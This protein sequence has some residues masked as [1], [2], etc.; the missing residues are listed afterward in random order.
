MN[1]IDTHFSIDDYLIPL[2]PHLPSG[3]FAA[4][5]LSNIRSIARQI[6]GLAS[7]FFGFESPLGIVDARADFL[8]CFKPTESGREI[9]SGHHDSLH[10]PNQY[11][12]TPAWQRVKAFSETWADPNSSLYNKVENTW[13]EFDIAENQPAIPLPSFFFGTYSAIQAKMPP[14]QHQ[15]VTGGALKILL[16]NTL[17]IDTQ[18]QLLTCFNALPDGAYVFQVGTMLARETDAVRICIR[19]IAPEQVVPYLLEVGWSGSAEELKELV[20]R[21]SGLVDRVDLDLDVGATVY[22]KIGLECYLNMQPKFEP[23]WARFLNGLV[24]KGLCVPEKQKALLAYPGYN[25]ERM[26]T[27]VWPKQLLTMSTLLGAHYLSMI[28]RSIHHIKIVYQPEAPLQAKAYLAV[29]HSFLDTASLKTL[30]MRTLPKPTQPP[31]Q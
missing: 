3:L 31:S 8:L 9:L 30:D 4:Q 11:F 21:L 6:P 29:T 10:L 15:W 25:H 20:E 19:G 27:D 7:S 13:L 17:P 1:N 14:H 16:N 23:R 2:L 26:N 22:P 18:R 12:T 24:E 5:A 28:I